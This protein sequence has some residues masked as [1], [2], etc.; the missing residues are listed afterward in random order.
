MHAI[1]LCLHDADDGVDEQRDLARSGFDKDEV[2][3][4][5]DFAKRTIKANAQIKHG[6]DLAVDIDHAANACGR[7]RQRRDFDRTN[8]LPNPH[9]IESDALLIQREHS[10]RMRG[11]RRHGPASMAF[12]GAMTIPV[13][14]QRLRM[15]KAARLVYACVMI[16]VALITGASRGIGRGIA[17]TLARAARHHL[18]I[19]YAGNKNAGRECQQLCREASDGKIEAEI[20]DLPRAVINI[21]SVSAF[22]TSTDRG[23]YCMSKAGIAMMTKL[24]AARLAEFGI[25][26][27]EIQPGIIESDMTEPVK[28]K[29][30]A[31]LAQGLAPINRWAQLS[32]V[33]K[34]VAAVA[35]G[36]FPYSTG[37]VFNVDGGF[38]LRIL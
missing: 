17:L 36:H 20:E 29:Y 34:A 11:R 1:F 3:R 31:L 15:A 32:D 23:D 4:G 38:H 10:H 21:S 13:K 2:I 7:I 14:W 28:A 30:G 9:H 33:G 5:V 37:H 26:V 18:G 16:G 6:R 22:T 19:N 12:A 8:H 24:W 35:L 25:G 27:F